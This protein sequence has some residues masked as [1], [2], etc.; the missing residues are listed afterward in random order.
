MIISRLFTFSSIQKINPHPHYLDFVNPQAICQRIALEGLPFVTVPLL[1]LKYGYVFAMQTSLMWGQCSECMCSTASVFGF[2][3]KKNL[4][5]CDG[6][7]M[8][9]CMFTHRFSALLMAY[10]AI[11]CRASNDPIFPI[12]SYILKICRFFPIKRKK[13][14]YFLQYIFHWKYPLVKMFYI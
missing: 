14:L 6:V 13:L 7:C 1:S 2:N 11:V 8:C 5:I 10:R 4:C 3:E 9:A 12:Y